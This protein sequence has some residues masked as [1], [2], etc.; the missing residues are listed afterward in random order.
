[1]VVLG[2]NASCGTK[3]ALFFE[4]FWHSLFLCRL[5]AEI[6]FVFSPSCMTCQVDPPWGAHIYGRRGIWD[7]TSTCH[8][9]NMCNGGHTYI[10]D[11]GFGM[12]R[13]DVIACI[14]AIGEHIANRGV[15]EVTKRK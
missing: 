3:E 13:P 5:P 6:F 4:Y 2:T 7:V 8:G 1:M 10:G 15:K 9:M 14:R 12:L 11:V